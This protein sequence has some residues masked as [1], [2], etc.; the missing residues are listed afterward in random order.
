ML[1][2]EHQTMYQY[3]PLWLTVKEVFTEIFFLANHNVISRLSERTTNTYNMNTPL[4]KC[5]HIYT[6]GCIHTLNIIN[7]VI[8]KVRLGPEIM[9][10]SF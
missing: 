5:T 3:S 4:Y 10:Y 7:H 8:G 6:Q 2:D 9:V 1:P